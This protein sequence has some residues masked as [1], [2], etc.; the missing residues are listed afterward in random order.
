MWSGTAARRTSSGCSAAVHSSG[1]R[2]APA[3]SGPAASVAAGKA[4]SR[5]RVAVAGA[6]LL[7]LA[8][9]L[10]GC[11]AKPTNPDEL[12][13]YNENNDPLEP[14]NRELFAAN[15]VVD[16]NVLHPVASG[17]RDVTPEPVRSHLHNVLS[18]LGNPAQFT[19][20]VLQGKP[21][22]AGNTFMRLILNTTVG[23]GGVFDVATGLGFPDH[24]TDFGLTL[25]IWG[26]PNG[27]FLFLPVLGPSSPR[28][29]VG[30]GINT[31]LDPFTWLSFG[32]SATLGYARFAAGAVDARSRVLDQTDAVER[33]ALD[34][35]ASF[36]SLYQQHRQSA[37][38]DGHADLPPTVPNWYSGH[39]TGLNAAPPTRQVPEVSPSL[40]PP[41]A[42][43][44]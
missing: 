24:D 26:V 37:V 31:T 3:S 5:W 20:D 42:L 14:M 32:G 6:A 18:N 28:D 41:A 21:R 23:V 34:P 11:A 43:T 16:R 12:A 30:Y 15:E 38:E 33:T 4:G 22:K 2:D 17:Y 39:S 9:V 10:P 1:Q 35:Y 13:E 29:G 19:N 8:T 27:P 25:A 36:R 44:P 40:A 7:A